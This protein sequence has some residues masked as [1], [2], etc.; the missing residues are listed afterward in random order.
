[1][2]VPTTVAT[3]VQ[4]YRGRATDRELRDHQLENRGQCGAFDALRDV[5]RLEPWITAETNLRY[6]L[7]VDELEE[8]RQATKPAERSKIAGLAA[9]IAMVWATRDMAVA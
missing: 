3:I 5:R 1:M 9:D 4:T 2:S 7:L 6:A 8:L